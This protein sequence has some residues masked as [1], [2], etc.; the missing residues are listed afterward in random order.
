MTMTGLLSV[1]SHER[2]VEESNEQDD[3]DRM[4]SEAYHPYK[5]IAEQR[6]VSPSL[7]EQFLV[8]V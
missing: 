5:S 6:F 7:A 4:N 2:S 1:L 3:H 8:S